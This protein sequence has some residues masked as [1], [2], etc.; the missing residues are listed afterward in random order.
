MNAEVYDESRLQRFFFLSKPLAGNKI[1]VDS[2][3]FEKAKAILSCLDAEEDVLHDAVRCP[4]CKSSRIEYPQFTR[5][6][7]TPTLVEIFC[8]LKIIDKEYYCENCQHTWA[9][10]VKH[11]RPTDTLGWP[12]NEEANPEPEKPEKK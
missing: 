5:K 4:Q 11:E 3:D 9:P 6:F 7:V 1:L 12:I 8:V 2:K 10:V